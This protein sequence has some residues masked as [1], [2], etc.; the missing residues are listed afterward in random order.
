MQLNLSRVA[1][2]LTAATAT[3]LVV[4]IR[5]L[6]ADQYQALATG[7]QALGVTVALVFGA[8]TLLADTHSRKVDRALGLHA[9]LT[10]GDVQ[11]ARVR[12][13][14]RLQGTRAEGGVRPV[15][16]DRLRTDDG[17]AAYAAP[18]RGRPLRDANVVLR[19]FERVN[20]ARVAGVVDLPLLH[21]LIG[22]HVLWWDRAI[23]RDEGEPLRGGLAELA[24]WVDRHSRTKA[25]DAHYLTS[26][27]RYLGRDFGEP[28]GDPAALP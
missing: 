12:L 6:D 4:P 17:F 20:A 14:V 19:Y 27:A 25:R 18:E 10:A 28:T 23:A 8:G 15:T 13:L 26:W 16:L 21:E 2:A 11:A 22:V 5:F 1:V 9:E 7:V 24:A 3:L